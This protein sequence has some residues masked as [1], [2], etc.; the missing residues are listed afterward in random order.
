[1]TTSYDDKDF[2]Y[3]VFAGYQINQYFGVEGG[4]TDLGSYEA[5]PSTATD[6]GHAKIDTY[7]L[8]LFAVGTAPITDRFSGFAKLG[9]SRNHSKMKFNSSGVSFNATDSGSDSRY[10]VAWGWGLSADIADNISARV[11]YE[12]FG[13]AG[14][15]NGDFTIAGKTSD[16]H[17]RMLSV[18][19]QYNF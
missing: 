8:N 7:S 16:S 9:L 4:F 13:K 17:P 5:T 19:L 10:S 2:A 18:G 3:K 12:D 11:E 6:T 14:E 15:S 1:M